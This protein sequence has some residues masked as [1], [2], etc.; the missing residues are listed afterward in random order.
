MALEHY[1]FHFRMAKRG[2]STGWKL[3]YHEI[4]H[5]RRKAVHRTLV[6]SCS[7][8][9]S[10]AVNLNTFDHLSTDGNY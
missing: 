2:A 8:F 5:T 4:L 6:V 10:G 1:L 9:H 7:G 3:L